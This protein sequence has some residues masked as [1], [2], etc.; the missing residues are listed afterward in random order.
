MRSSVTHLFNIFLERIMPDALEEQDRKVSIG[1]RN[2]TKLRFADD[3]YALAEEVQ[4][5]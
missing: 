4:E 1:G 5:L 3:T 2:F